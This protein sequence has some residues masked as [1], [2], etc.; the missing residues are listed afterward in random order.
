MA[1]SA[2]P[3]AM[4]QQGGGSG[5][6][7]Q[8]AAAPD[9][10][11]ARFLMGAHRY[12]EALAVL[13][14]LV[15]RRR[16]VETDAIF[17]AG[18]AALGASQR[19]G[20]TENTRNALLDEAAAYFRTMLIGRPGLDRVRLEL[21]RVYFLRGKDELARNQ[22]ERVLAGQPPPVVARNVNRFLA[23]IRVRER[24]SVN[25][26]FAL[27]PD[28]NVGATS[29]QRTIEINGL[30]FQR[31][32]QDLTTAAVGLWTWV[33]AEYNFNLGDRLPLRA[34]GYIS[35][36]DYQASE[37]DRTYASAHFGPR[38]RVNRGG[39][40]DVS[41]LTSVRESWLA[42][43]REYRDIGLRAETRL[44]F[45]QR[46]NARV[47][48]GRHE[49]R[50]R[51]RT[52]LDGPVTDLYLSV[53]HLVSPTVQFQSAAG[54]G[55]ERTRIL[56]YSNT[57]HWIRAG[58]AVALPR[59]FTVGG[60]GMYGRADY[61]GNWFPFT[62]GESRSDRIRSFR[63]FVHNRALSLGGFSPQI[64]VAHET[65]ITNAQ[66]YNYRRNFVEV[67]FARPF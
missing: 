57:S 35:R 49:R 2:D 20:R 62:D 18:L 4:H 9:L 21:G 54:W 51:A 56:K 15:Q 17:I 26:G 52:H 32:A 37:F 55:T 29:E 8:Q 28:S 22:F 3:G 44:Q 59:G 43:E 1:W 23:E 63:V 34:G 67:S 47:S 38:W 5:G 53:S 65:R 7:I 66:L 60:G 19:P 6:S 16:V 13:R 42:N 39:D 58:L 36:R 46:V 50:H 27:T 64:S 41:L 25:A 61:E 31:D 30:P 14:P 24:W 10:A 48:V 12:G 45:G 40:N 33:D 11:R